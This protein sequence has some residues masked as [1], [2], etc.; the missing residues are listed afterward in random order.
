MLNVVKNLFDCSWN[1]TLIL[2]WCLLRHL[3]AHS[4]GLSTTCLTVGKYAHIIP[5]EETL[6]QPLNLII[7]LSLS[8]LLVEYTIEV[9]CLSTLLPT[10]YLTYLLRST[11]NREL[12]IV[13]GTYCFLNHFKWFRRPSVGFEVLGQKWPHSHEY[14][15]VTFVL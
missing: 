4:V 15:N 2:Q 7:N 11:L 3:G 1:D 10:A 6:N 13:N 9:E 14:P 5:I 12:S 8:T